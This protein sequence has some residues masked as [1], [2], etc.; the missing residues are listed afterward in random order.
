[1]DRNPTSIPRNVAA[2]VLQHV[3]TAGANIAQHAIPTVV[4][5][6]WTVSLIQVHLRKLREGEG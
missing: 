3:R 4:L 6:V 5:Q 1:M 2:V